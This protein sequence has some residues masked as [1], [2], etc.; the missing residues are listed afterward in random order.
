MR[1]KRVRGLQGCLVTHSIFCGCTSIRTALDAYCK[2]LTQ[3][4]ALEG[5]ADGGSWIMDWI[6]IKKEKKKREL[7]LSKTEFVY[8]LPDCTRSI[9][10]ISIFFSFACV[11]HIHALV[12]ADFRVVC[13]FGDESAVLECALCGSS[14]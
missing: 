5:R 11:T 2:D 8:P 9:R 3:G 4:I 10:D 1:W 7:L 12:L 6:L 13:A 14:F